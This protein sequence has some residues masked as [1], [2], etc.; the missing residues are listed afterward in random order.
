MSGRVKPSSRANISRAAKTAAQKAALLA[1]QFT[2]HK[3]EIVGRV[4]K[5]AVP[6]AMF[7]VGKVDGIL[8]STVRDGV[9]E[10]YIHKFA[11]KDKPV[12][13]VSPNGKQ[14][15]FIGGHYT[16]TERGIVDKSDRG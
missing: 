10:K 9:A 8:Y 14:I 15:F 3:P 4:A 13:C 5:P 6:D 11:A 2:G 1:E 12:L 7:A 16:F